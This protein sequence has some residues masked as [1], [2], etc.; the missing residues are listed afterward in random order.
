V[1]RGEVVPV[2]QADAV[3]VAQGV[4]VCVG[5]E[6][7]ELLTVGER[8]AVRET[9]T[10]LVMEPPPAPSLGVP[11]GAADAEVEPEEEVVPVKVLF[12]VGEPGGGLLT[13]A[14]LLGVTREEG[15]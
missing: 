6:E 9:D 4:T 15:V 13:V 3:V 1:A 2:A 7:V 11:V 14:E 10:V 5:T 8:V 12:P